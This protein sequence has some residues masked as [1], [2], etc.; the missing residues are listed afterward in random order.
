MRSETRERIERAMDQLGYRPSQ[1]ARQ[2]R[3]GQAPILGLII[4]SVANPFWGSFAQ[5]V[6]EA[7]RGHEYQVLL[8]S[9]GRDPEREEC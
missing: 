9:G 7:A 2:L 5:Y 8:C 1:V 3:T 4:P 6:E